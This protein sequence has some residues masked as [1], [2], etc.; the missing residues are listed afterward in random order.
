MSVLSFAMAAHMFLISSSGH[1]RLTSGG[2]GL[3][4]GHTRCLLLRVL[5]TLP[6]PASGN[7]SCLQVFRCQGYKV[8]KLKIC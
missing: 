5:N 7:Y 6:S 1:L 4:L 2:K 8:I 3:P